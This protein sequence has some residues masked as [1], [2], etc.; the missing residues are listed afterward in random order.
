MDFEAF[1]IRLVEGL[2]YD[3]G[4]KGGRRPFDPVSMLKLLIVQTHRNLPDARAGFMPRNRLSGMRFAG[5][6]LCAPTPDETAIRHFPNKLTDNGTL[7]AIM[8][9]CDAQ[10]RAKGFLPMLGQIVDASL[11]PAPSPRNTDREKAFQIP[12]M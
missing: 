12:S 1:R 6:D 9:L 5:F 4:V 11:V 8:G 7:T 2:G 3:D 10:L